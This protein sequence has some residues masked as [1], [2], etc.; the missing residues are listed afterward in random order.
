[1]DLIKINPLELSKTIC[2]IQS[3]SFLSLI[4][5]LLNLAKLEMFNANEYM[6]YRI[7]ELR[8]KNVKTWFIM[9][10]I[11]TTETLVKLNPV[12]VWIFFR[13]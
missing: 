5:I 4:F 13:L 2:K 1:M 3:K 12:Q 7:F 6:K 8:R 9:T 10:V 11:H